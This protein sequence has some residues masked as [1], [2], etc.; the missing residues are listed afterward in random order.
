MLTTEV[1][2]VGAGPA[3]ISAA[4]VAREAGAQVIL[5]DD[6]SAPGG[7]LFKQIHKFFGSQEH[8]AGTR[9][10][11]IGRQLLDRARALDVDIRL[12]TQVM[13]I[14]E[15]LT[16]GIVHDGRTMQLQA[17]K[18]ILTTG[19][20]ENRLAFPGWTLP[21]IMTAGAA[22]TL[23]NIHR[24]LPGRQVLMVGAGNVGLIVSYQLLQAGADVVAVVEALPNIG[25]YWVHASKLRRAGVPILTHHTILEARGKER[26]KE[27][28]VAQVDANWKPIPGTER[29]LAVDA[30]C[31]AVGLAPSTRLTAMAGCQHRWDPVRGGLVPIHDESFETTVPSLYLAGD[32][33][34]VEEATTAMEQGRIAGLAAAHSLGYLAGGEFESL[35]AEAQGRLAR[36]QRLPSPIRLGSHA[37]QTGILE[38]VD[39]EGLPGM[40]SGERMDKGP[41][42]V[43]ECAQE[44]PCNPCETSCFRHAVSLHGSLTSLPELDAEK[45]SGCGLC[46]VACPGQAVFIVDLSFGPGEATVAF[47][48][49][50]LPL[51]VAGATVKAT[52]RGGNP[53]CPARVIKVDTRTRYDK[54]AIVTVSVP[55]ENAHLVRGI[56]WRE[57]RDGVGSQ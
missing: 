15:G 56:A 16:L 24:V 43:M 37:A 55:R 1:A 4:C 2:V 17:K 12:D 29:T 32:V 33:A 35:R 31:L 52:D 19:A 25:G 47:P 6:Q 23:M 46:L 39:L 48:Y 26:V 51:P 41:V 5:F 38:A 54:T 14:F 40:P 36:L 27:A 53:V 18:T 11:V 45:C 57:L 28:L 7:Q 21:G 49:E 30:I 42:A 9:G 20:E 50:F 44:I 3:G 34:G 13:G 10:F 22:Q 8:M